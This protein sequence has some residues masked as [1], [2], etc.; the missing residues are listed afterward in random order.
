MPR[1]S[2]R[3]GRS[4]TRRRDDS[5][6]RSEDEHAKT[7][8]PAA[9]KW[10]FL[11]DEIQK[12]IAAKQVEVLQ[13]SHRITEEMR[14][15]R[16][17]AR[18][19]WYS[20]KFVA[21][22]AA[23]TAFFLLTAYINALGA[24]IA[25]WRTPNLQSNRGLP[26]IM[27]DIL[28][29]KRLQ[30]LMGSEVTRHLPDY[31][32]TA[33]VTAGA[34]ATY[35]DR[36]RW[37]IVRRFLTIFGIVNIMRA[38]CV[39]ATSLPDTS[40]HCS[41][42]WNHM[43][44]G[45]SGH[46]KT[47]PMFPR[48][49]FRALKLISDPSV[50]TCGDLIFSGHTVTYVLFTLIVTHYKNTHLH[51]P[52][53]FWQTDKHCLYECQIGAHTIQLISTFAWVSC[54]C[55]MLA[56]LATE[57]HYTVDV[58]I[59]FYVAHRT[60]YFYHDTAIVYSMYGNSENISTGRPVKQLIQWLEDDGGRDD[61]LHAPKSDVGEKKPF[62]LSPISDRKHTLE[63]SPEHRDEKDGAPSLLVASPSQIIMLVVCIFAVL[64]LA[65]IRLKNVWVDDKEIKMLP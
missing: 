49:F 21:R 42:Q 39:V 23:A 22:F 25:G 55:G 31:F 18:A 6:G 41:D 57:F 2:Q 36:R 46:Y 60:W 56:I 9:K 48:A 17:E 52:P 20:Q 3:R 8:R 40:P 64:I 47:V 33:H 13:L 44:P 32:I 28:P 10:N 12:R 34:I 24:T 59:G 51:I 29:I 37:T 7:T 61:T 35:L 16:D 11:R 45:G 14:N 15:K 27:R 4:K 62:N 58:A 26:D 50:T 54:F 19:V 1:R 5:R 65:Y 53:L 43:S 30:E 38:F 63:S